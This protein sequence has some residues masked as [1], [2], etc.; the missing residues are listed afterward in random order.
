MVRRSSIVK[1]G[2]SSRREQMGGRHHELRTMI[3]KRETW[4]ETN[5]RT[6]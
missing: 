6:Q 4:L 3:G 5:E 2:L 1:E